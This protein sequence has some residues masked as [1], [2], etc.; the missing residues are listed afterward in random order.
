MT[1]LVP[2]DSYL[3]LEEANRYHA[4]RTSKAEWGSLSDEEKQQRLVSASDFLDINYRFLGAKRNPHQLRQFPRTETGG[5][6]RSGIPTQ[7]KHAICE[8]AL[9]SDLNKKPKQQMS[10]V[11]VGPVTVNYE[12]SE[13][14]NSADRFPNITKMLDLFLDK[15]ARMGKSKLIRG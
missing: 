2:E 10:S 4:Y 6:D 15:T 14:T 1:F 13:L 3:T 12:Q 8:L 5:V 7:V 11:R 9:F